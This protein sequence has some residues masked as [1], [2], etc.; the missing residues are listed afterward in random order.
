M[1]CIINKNFILEA[2][3]AVLPIEGKTGPT[4][5]SE[6][7]IYQFSPVNTEKKVKREKK[8]KLPGCA[9]RAFTKKSHGNPL[10]TNK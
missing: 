6:L 2:T 5:T 3:K 10:F 8:R 9:F 7:N 4:G 1:R